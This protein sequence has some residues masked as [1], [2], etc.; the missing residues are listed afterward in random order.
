MGILSNYKFS[1][2]G[3]FLLTIFFIV[4][5]SQK[6]IDLAIDNTYSVIIGFIVLS[7]ICITM[8]YTMDT[9]NIVSSTRGDQGNKGDS[10]ESGKIGPKGDTGE[11][12]GLLKNQGALINKSK[13]LFINRHADS[14]NNTLIIK[15]REYGTSEYWT[16]NVDGT[17]SNKYND[18]CVESNSKQ[19]KKLPE[20]KRCNKTPFQEWD[21]DSLGR[22][23]NKQ[24]DQC[25]SINQGNKIIMEDCSTN[26]KQK[27]MFI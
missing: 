5:K 22:L 13:N 1:I 16:F 15:D 27:W 23:K 9:R 3:M 2:I 4:M 11:T 19:S 24:T 17:I 6:G 12:G 21:W 20:M 10:G 18:D 25:L 8:F 7:G 14:N 26:E